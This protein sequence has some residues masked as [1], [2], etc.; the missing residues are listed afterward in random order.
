M[1]TTTPSM[2]KRTVSLGLC[3]SAAAFAPAPTG[4]FPA[5]RADATTTCMAKKFGQ[6]APSGAPPADLFNIW[7]DDY[8]LTPSQAAAE[9]A[10]RSANAFFDG[11]LPPFSNVGNQYF[12]TTPDAPTLAGKGQAR[13]FSTANPTS[14]YDVAAFGKA[15]VDNPD[16]IKNADKLAGAP[17]PG[18]R[19]TPWNAIT[20]EQD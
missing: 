4:P 2:L 10:E 14:A 7:R 17:L 8:M 11:I 19:D 9:E 18:Y 6:S 3:A 15:S 20:P 5:L 16:I 12:G 1:G 13:D